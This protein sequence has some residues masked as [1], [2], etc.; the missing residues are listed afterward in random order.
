MIV[1]CCFKFGRKGRVSTSAVEWHAKELCGI[2]VGLNQEY[3]VQEG[4]GSNRFDLGLLL[5]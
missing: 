2:W 1:K 4:C 3:I 5:L